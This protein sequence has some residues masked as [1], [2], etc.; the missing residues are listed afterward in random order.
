MKKIIIV[1]LILASLLLAVFTIPLLAKAANDT[2]T[3]TAS[4]S[5]SVAIT[6]PSNLSWATGTINVTAH[7]TSSV[8]INKIEFYIN[9]TLKSTDTTLPYSFLWDTTIEKDKIYKIEAK[10]YDNSGEVSSTIVVVKVINKFIAKEEKKMEKKWQKDYNKMLKKFLK[11]DNN[12]SEIHQKTNNHEEQDS[13]N[14]NDDE[15][16]DDND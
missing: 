10:A 15:G 6:I 3:P 8:G 1:P 16:E 2:S 12:Q 11:K 7:A 14:N 5:P 9:K 4:S 13:E